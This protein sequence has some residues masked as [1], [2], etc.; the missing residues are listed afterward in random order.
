MPSKVC[1]VKDMVFP[2]GVYGC[3]T[4]TIKKVECQRTAAFIRWCWRSLLGIP[5][6]VRRSN[7]IIP[8]EI[9]PEYSLVNIHWCW[10]SSTW[11]TWCEEPTNWKRP[12]W[13]ERLSQRG[14]TECEI[15]GWINVHHWLNRHEFEQ[16]LGDIK[17]RKTWHEAV[18]GVPKSPTWLSN[19]ITRLKLSYWLGWDFIWGSGFSSK[20]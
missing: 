12:W 6:T 16:T 19:W 5:W 3:E 8:K 9:S 10:S 7:Q 13:W 18:H 20:L 4:W 15:I 14:V 11:S 1:I 17:G 2:V